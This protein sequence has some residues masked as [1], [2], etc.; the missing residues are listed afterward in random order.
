MLLSF[1]S[2]FSLSVPTM[3]EKTFSFESTYGEKDVSLQ[4]SMWEVKD[5]EY[6]VLICPGYS[7]DRQKWRPMADLFVENGYTTMTFDYSGQGASNGTIGFD[8][9]K[10]DN[11]PVEIDDAI[12]VL[13]SKANVDYSKIILVGHS[14]GGRSILRLLYDYNEPIAETKVVKKEIAN[15][16]LMSPEVNYLHNT[17]ASLFAGTSDESEE[18]WKSFG[19]EHVKGSN[20]YM[21]GSTADDIVPGKDVLRIYERMGAINVPEDGKYKDVQTNEYGSKLSVQ[22]VGGVLHSYMMYSPQIARCINSALKDISGHATRFDSNSMLLVYAGWLFGLAGLGVTLFALLMDNKPS[23][24]MEM[25]AIPEL[26]DTK[27]FLLRKL[28][29]WVPGLLVAFLLCCLLM[30]LP[31]G[32]PIMNIPYMCFVA[33]YGLT[34]LIHFGKGHFPGT[35]GKLPKIEWR[36]KSGWKSILTGAGISLGVILF[37][38][39]V[40]RTSMYRLIPFNWR[41]FWVVIA[42]I[43]MTV[44]YYISGVESDMLKKSGA[45][46]WV[47]FLYQL[48][49]YVPLF[50]FVAFYLIIGSYS[51]FIGQ[52]QNMV[53][54]YVFCIPLG[55]LLRRKT[56]CRVCGALLTAFLFQAIMITSAA[57]ISFF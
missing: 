12:E 46:R 43:L 13:H 45:K 23:A 19:P 33:G 21:Y 8:N 3:N 47:R 35:E 57:L 38:W 9:A 53:L 51:G 37:V 24:E 56:G 30:V 6:A 49:Q 34:M 25:D 55:N 5:S 22:V 16:I 1:V 44:G 31:F 40:L 26:K 48:I 36:S 7:C 41:L 32:S 42:A 50:L 52:M 20:I 54:M 14:M 39:Y 4:A 2:L 18:P 27:K 17:Q 10:T 11:I 15:V 29:M 28:L